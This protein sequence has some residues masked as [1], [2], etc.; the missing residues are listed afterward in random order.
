MMEV[1][2]KKSKL[3]ASAKAIANSILHGVSTSKI[4]SAT[5][6]KMLGTDTVGGRRRSTVNFRGRMREFGVKATRFK[7]LRKLGANSPQMVRAAG[8]PAIMYGCHTTGISDTALDAARSKVANAASPAAGG[9]NP[10]LSLIALDGNAGTLDPAFE[11]HIGPAKHWA[12]AVWEKWQPVQQLRNAFAGAAN[13]L[14]TTSGSQWAMVSGPTTAVIASLD[15]ITWQMP[16]ATVM[17]TDLG[18]T[19]NLELDPPIVI[20]NECKEGVRRWRMRLANR[21]LPGLIPPMPDL[22][23]A[24]PAREDRIITTFGGLSALLKGKPCKEVAGEVKKD[25][26]PRAKGDLASAIS[27]GQ[28]TQVRKAGVTAWGIED[29]LCQLCKKQVGTVE[30]RFECSA[31][32]PTSGWP[33]PPVVADKALM[34]L[35]EQRR[36]IL[37]TRALAVIRLPP[38]Q[39][40]QEGQFRW[41]REP[42]WNGHDMHN[43]IWYCDG[44]LLNGRWKDLRATGFGIVIAT[45]EGRLLGYGL[46]WPPSWC[47]TA[48]AAEAW[49]L[50]TVISLCPFPPQMRTDCQTLLTMAAAGTQQAT[51]ANRPLAR[52]WQCIAETMGTDI[53]GLTDSGLLVWVPAHLNRNAVGESKLSDGR[54]LSCVDWRANRLVDKL[55]KT[56][57]RATSDAKAVVELAASLEAATNH[58]AALLG[59]VTH[60]ANNHMVTFVD[61]DGQSKQQIQRDSVDKPKDKRYKVPGNE[62]MAMQPEQPA[63]ASASQEPS[64]PRPPALWKQPRQETPGTRERKRQRE[65]LSNRVDAIGASL[66]PSSSAHAPLSAVHE[67]IRAKFARM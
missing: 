53:K 62:P 3:I 63:P 24:I 31:T 67:R 14:A 11:A 20:A 38:R 13:K 19:L 46:G 35:G 52:V 17:V 64:T 2:A 42:D 10:T 28:W 33:G 47:N 66:R 32:N 50:Q 18:K 6:S 56:A 26:H 40:H 60:A 30:H 44:S 45:V 36:K 65:A 54:R 58:A 51:M 61:E 57:A 49:A 48:A 23:P 15:R 16:S 43:A 12:L 37:K 41:L 4:G 5:H 1:S 21:I 22:G 8:T 59:I 7:S 55:A 27:G 9:K 34:K 29:N 25:W 39:W